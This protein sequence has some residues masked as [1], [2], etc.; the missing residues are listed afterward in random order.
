[1]DADD[2]FGCTAAPQSSQSNKY[3][4]TIKKTPESVALVTPGQ[5]PAVECL[6]LGK[7][8]SLEIFN[9]IIIFFACVKK[10]LVISSL[11]FFTYEHK[12]L[13]RFN[14]KINFKYVLFIK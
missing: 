4:G 9:C 11:Y 10:S 13:V 12:D 7:I 3:F 14:H 1:M 2:H 6:I 5:Q 8:V